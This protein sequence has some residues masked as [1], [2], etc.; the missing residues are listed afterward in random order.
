MRQPFQRFGIKKYR[1]TDLKGEELNGTFYEGELQKVSY[2]EDKFFEIEKVLN[3]RGRG[4]KE[5]SLVKWKGWP[6]KFNTWVCL[7]TI[8]T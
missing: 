2:V 7:N 1:L 5:E 4:N 8:P 6:D 3:K